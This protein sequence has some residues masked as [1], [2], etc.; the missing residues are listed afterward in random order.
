L[1]DLRTTVRSESLRSD[2]PLRARDKPMDM[3]LDMIYASIC[4]VISEVEF[5]S[6][7]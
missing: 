2:S 6:I 7:A 5:G 1:T 3:G 4:L